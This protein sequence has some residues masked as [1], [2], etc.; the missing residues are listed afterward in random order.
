VTFNAK[1]I[2]PQQ[3]SVQSRYG[4]IKADSNGCL[5]HC[6]TLFL[7]IMVGNLLKYIS[8]LLWIMQCYKLFLLF[9][10]IEGKIEGTG[11]Q[12]RRR[13]QLLYDLKENKRCWKLE[14]RALDRILSKI[15]FERGHGTVVRDLNT[16]HVQQ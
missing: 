14:E 11:R 2:F 15:G 9:N 10:V 1:I 6:L 4:W 8:N 5:W 13:K 16:H 12:G 7:N 3:V